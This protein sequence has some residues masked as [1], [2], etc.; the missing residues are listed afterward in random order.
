M[1]EF[2]VDNPQQ[3]PQSCQRPVSALLCPEEIELFDYP[4]LSGQEMICEINNY[5]LDFEF[6]METPQ[7]EEK[8]EDS[9]SEGEMMEAIST[10][11]TRGL[12]ESEDEITNCGSSLTNKKNLN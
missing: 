5:D 12:Y 1:N 4:L 10:F 2:S 7:G 9:R 8:I 11:E 3:E 6:E